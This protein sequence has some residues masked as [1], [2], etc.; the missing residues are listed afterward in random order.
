M[1]SNPANG[2]SLGI[3]IDSD[4]CGIEQLSALK[5][6][7]CGKWAIRLLFLLSPHC[8]AGTSSE[9]H[10]LALKNFRCSGRSGSA[11]ISSRAS[12]GADDG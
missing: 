12:R 4:F 7:L 5:A 8:S 10:K 1:E 3:G 11:D 9:S 2:I 6:G